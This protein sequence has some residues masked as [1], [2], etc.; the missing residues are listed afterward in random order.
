MRPIPK[1]RTFRTALSKISTCLV[2]ICI[3]FS[4][5]TCGSSLPKTNLE[6]RK[7]FLKAVGLPILV[8]IQPRH[9]KDKKELQLFIKTENLTK[10]NISKF[11]ILFFASDGNRQLL[12][13]DESKT[14]ELICSIQ[15]KIQPNSIYKCLVGPYVFTQLWNSIQ[16]QS[17]SFTTEDQIRHVIDEEDLNDVIL[18]L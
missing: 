13:P 8:S 2:N 5:G 10:V 15:K 14:P 6:E 1:N 4:I 12:I 9:N 7:Q 3:C 17:I 11:Q 16:V 18:W